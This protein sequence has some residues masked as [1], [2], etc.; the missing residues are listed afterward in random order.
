LFANFI[1]QYMITFY[2]RSNQSCS[3]FLWRI[4]RKY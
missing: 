1:R 4:Y 3:K 2:G